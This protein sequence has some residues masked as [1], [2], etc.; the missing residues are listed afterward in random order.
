[1]VSLALLSPH[2]ARIYWAVP[3]VLSRSKPDLASTRSF[4]EGKRT[5]AVLLLISQRL[6]A[7]LI[8]LWLMWQW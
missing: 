7:G 1:M 3:P 5:G 2:R 6:S 4:L 8:P